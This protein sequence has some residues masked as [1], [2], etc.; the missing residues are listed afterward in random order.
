MILGFKVLEKM[1]IKIVI[2]F[3]LLFSLSFTYDASNINNAY[4]LYRDKNYKKAAELLEEE[5]K[6]TPI[7][8]IEYYEMLA[9]AYMYMK[10]YNNML[11]VARDGI[12][13]NRFSH[14]LY[15]QKGYALYKLGKTNEAIEPIR[16]SLILNPDD[17]Y[18]NNF[19]GLLYLYTEDYKLAE[20]SFLKANIYSTNNIVYM[21]NLA[22]TYERDKNYV[23][24]LKIYEDVY[25]IDKTYRNVAESI[26]RVKNYLGYTNEDIK[27]VNTVETA[28]N[29][30]T[31]VNLINPIENTNQTVITNNI[32]TNNIINTNSTVNTNDTNS[33][34]TNQ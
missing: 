14:K 27:V 21:I 15:F 10:D 7:L 2:L 9:N 28:H 30:D 3:L 4:R 11:R 5:I 13:V 31:E 33:S 22:A 23:S 20:A 18:M 16:H 26:N 19:L 17:A 8:K 6:T 24:A 1:K 34:T 32:Y 29:E 12:I 25:N